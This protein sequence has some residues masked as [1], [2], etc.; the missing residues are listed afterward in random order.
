MTSK[1][2]P[3]LCAAALLGPAAAA[4]TTLP[5][6]GLPL[7]NVP[8]AVALKAS[9]FPLT[10]VRLLDGPFR[11]AQELD[12]RYLLSLE[13][14]RL[15]H[16]FRLHAGLVPKAPPYGGWELE[17]LSGHTLGHYLSACALMYAATGDHAFGDIVEELSLCQ[18]ARRTGYVGAIPNEDTIFAQVARGE[19]RA[20]GFALNG[21][22]S[23]WYT[24]HKLLAGLLDAYL[25]T[26]NARALAVAAR[27]GDWTETALR[28]LS[29]DQMLPRRRRSPLASMPRCR[30]A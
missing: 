3:M 15:L 6:A 25:Q 30:R 16:R 5:E 29:P 18:E 27:F 4:Q 21:G 1:L 24:L 20:T 17:S 26:G 14:D 11:R 13:P 12:G 23:P 2:L 19:I 7:V 10:D 8:P 28:T 22:W 9:A